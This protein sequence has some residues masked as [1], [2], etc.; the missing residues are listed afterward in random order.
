MPTDKQEGRR[1]TLGEYV[2]NIF[3][4]ECYVVNID[5]ARAYTMDTLANITWYSWIS[6]SSFFVFFLKENYIW[7]VQVE[8]SAFN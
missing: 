5:S 4:L 7:V 3:V 8:R 1:H 2:T 6:L